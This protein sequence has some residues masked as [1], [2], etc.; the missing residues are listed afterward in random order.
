MP[1][2]IVKLKDNYLEW[3]TVSD[4]PTTRGMTREQMRQYLLEKGQREVEA[5]VESRLMRVDMHGSSAVPPE[6][7]EDIMTVNRAG[8]NESRLTLD[9]IYERCCIPRGGDE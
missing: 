7:A 5:E 6:T 4:S 1:K 2:Y 3:S 8:K 9:E